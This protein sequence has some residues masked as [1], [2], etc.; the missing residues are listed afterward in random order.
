MS[1]GRGPGM[2]GDPVNA[3]VVLSSTFHQGGQVG[4]SRE[5]NPTWEAFEEALGALEG[6][7]AVSF[8]SGMAAVAAVVER[9][10]VGG[11]LVLP[12]AAYSGTRSLATTLEQRGRLVARRVDVTDTAATLAACRG[13]D[14]LW[15][16][17]PTNP[18]LGVAD[19]AALCAGAR[20]QGVVAAADNTFAT[21]LLQR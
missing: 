1:A 6:G 18:L 16:E 8:A 3:P 7:E 19:L 14:L 10:P 11:T 21:P 12:G 17:S 9:V 4:Y 2:P 20:R 13:A 5:S 15:L